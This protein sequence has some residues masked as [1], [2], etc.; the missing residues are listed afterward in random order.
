MRKKEHFTNRKAY[1]DKSPKYIGVES[2]FAPKY[3]KL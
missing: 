1:N 3:K 2:F